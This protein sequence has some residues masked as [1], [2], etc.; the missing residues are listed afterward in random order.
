MQP[1][2]SLHGINQQC[3]VFYLMVDP[4]VK[5]HALPSLFYRKYCHDLGNRM[6]IVDANR[7]IVHLRII[8]EYMTAYIV[9]GFDHL[10]HVY[11]LLNGGT[12]KLRFLL[13][14]IFYVIKVRDDKM[15]S[16]PIVF[17]SLRDPYT[18][19]ISRKGKEMV[20]PDPF[21]DE[22]ERLHHATYKQ[23]KKKK[24]RMHTSTSQLHIT[25]DATH[26]QKKPIL[27]TPVHHPK[28]L[29]IDLNELP[30][31]DD[32]DPA[33]SD[34]RG[35]EIM[36][37]N[38]CTNRVET[39]HSTYSII[40]IKFHQFLTTATNEQFVELPNHPLH[41][42]Q[43]NSPTF[44]Q[45]IPINRP[46]GS[47]YDT[48]VCFI[49]IHQARSCSIVIPTDFA[50]RAFPSRMDCVCLRHVGGIEY[51]MGLRWTYI[52][53]FVEVQL[54]RGWR[55]FVRHNLLR[56]GSIIRLTVTSLNESVMYAELIKI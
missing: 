20:P 39:D 46:I 38:A 15:A 8:K 22:I 23:K 40:P 14:D 19:H 50:V 54:T 36:E 27:H 6:K 52:L 3:R 42:A 17:F 31:I 5:M 26:F 44:T 12:M 32:D 29:D 11:R 7:N 34:N 49:T 55:Y 35:P 16:I 10:V 56:P 4:L 18:D 53:S 13:N 45:F 24:K 48:Y 47:N 1:A 21:F 2:Q 43:L 41:Y 9:E 25:A 51:N 37:D 33:D 28:P 30:N